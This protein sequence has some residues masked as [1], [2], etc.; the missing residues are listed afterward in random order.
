MQYLEFTFHTSPE[1]EATYDLLCEALS[2]AG[3]DSFAHTADLD[4]PVAE[5]TDN[6][7]AP[8]CRR[9]Q[10][11]VDTFKAY[12]PQSAFAQARLDQALTQFSCLMNELLPPEGVKV[13]YTCRPAEDRDWNAEW[14]QH[15][16]Q[17]L[18][19]SSVSPYTRASQRQRTCVVASTFHKDVPEADYKILINPQMSFGTG[20]H[21]TTSQMLSRLLRDN[22]HG[23][24]VLDMGCGT[25]ILAI[26]ASMRGAKSCLA[27]DYDEWC[28]KNTRENITLNHVEGIEVRLGDIASLP[29][30]YVSDNPHSEMA[31]DL[32]S[33]VQPFRRFDVVL[34]NINRNIILENIQRFYDVMAP[35]AN[36][37]M[38]G[39]YMDDVKAIT[40]QAYLIG[41]NMV[42]VEQQDGWACVKCCKTHIL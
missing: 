32:L 26:L 9:P 29:T 12:I 40:D 6:P 33:T 23:K 10:G 1:S 21:A 7:E 31:A 35:G 39:F 2:T 36:I 24:R 14:E 27:V 25:G 19:V 15:Y 28:V 16:F 42:D 22:M 8:V 13:D 4:L 20:H 5:R 34:A 41:L 18:V 37:Y 17:P 3:F 11:A 38:S 30:H